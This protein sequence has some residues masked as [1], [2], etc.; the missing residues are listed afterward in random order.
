MRELNFLQYQLVLYSVHS[1][2]L[3]INP[4]LTNRKLAGHILLLHL[5]ML[6]LCL[7]L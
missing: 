2:T 3:N 4:W 7:F 1:P 5:E 6:I